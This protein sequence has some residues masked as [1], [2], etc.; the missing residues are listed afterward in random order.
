MIGVDNL[1]PY[2]S[3]AAKAENLALLQKHPG[4]TFHE[5]DA[6]V[7]GLI[8]QC[9][10]EVVVH[11]AA[12]VGVRHSLE[13]VVEYNRVNVGG[14]LHVLE[15]ARLHGVR[16]VVYASS[17]SVY[18][19]NKKLPFSE[20]DSTETCRSPYACDKLV[21]EVYA[22]L[23]SR[24]HGL[25]TTGLRFFTVYGPRGRPDMAI[26]RLLTAILAGGQ[27][28]KYGSGDSMRDYTYVDDI[29]DG[30][31]GAIDQ[32]TAEDGRGRI[33]NLGRS[34]PVSLNDL[35]GLCEDVS[36]RPAPVE[37]IGEQVGDVPST[38]ADT[39]RSETDLGYSPKVSLR[40]GLR[41]THEWLVADTTRT[42]L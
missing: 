16:R 5:E 37:E 14:F 1:D 24:I 40:E 12:K 20:N 34:D 23:Y 18:G 31:V 22:K 21:M 25:E 33:Y 2:Y 6:C 32:G 8:G 26:R 41:R 28:R 15:E 36:G 7:T 19:A 11:L 38:W 13:N 10:P 39:T 9:K 35:I 17:S 3:P 30:I 4:F 27:F 29:V 42:N